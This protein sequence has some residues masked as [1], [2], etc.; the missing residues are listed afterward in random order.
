MKN[1]L[2]MIKIAA[3]MLIIT[4]FITELGAQNLKVI[5]YNI[6]FNNPNDGINAWPNRSNF[7]GEL[8]VFHEADIF[9]LQEALI[10][11][12]EDIEKQIP[13]MNWVGV[14]RDDGKSSGE[15]SPIF[16]NN[17]KFELADKGWFWLSETPDK[18]SL[19]WEAT[20]K[21]ICTWVL[22]KDLKNKQMFYVFNTHFDHIAN[23]A[24]ANSA[25]LIIQKLKNINT[26]NL[27]VVLIGD[28]N[29]TPEKE[30]I[31]YLTQELSDAYKASLA[32]PYGPTGTFN[33][34]DFNSKL[35]DRIDY[36]FVN[37]Y[38]KVLKYAALS[39]SKNQKYP[40]DHLPVFAELKFVKK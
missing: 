3:I 5:T 24:R 31:H 17:Q 15:F 39:D 14:G 13:S 1:R 29:L 28:F 36:I 18:P 10:G 7:V 9:G 33:G 37:Q 26:K 38:F 22:L 12:I 25:R 27:P 6:R 11:Q 16:Y 20:Y 23:L 2:Q 32:P 4:A 21:R 30:P 40:S 8:L 34:F 35:E 19:G